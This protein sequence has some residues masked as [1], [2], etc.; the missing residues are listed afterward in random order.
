MDPACKK[1]YNIE[2]VYDVQTVK[3]VKDYYGKVIKTNKDL[4]TGA[5]CTEEPIPANIEA[6][7]KDI[8]PKVL[9]RY[10]GCGSPF[11]PALEGKTVLDLGSGSGRDCFILSKLVG[12][13][14]KVIGVD[15][16]DEQLEIANSY[17]SYHT[18]RFGYD[19]PNVIFKKGYIEDLQSIGIEDESID[20]VVSNG[21]LNLSTNKRNV[22]SEIFRVLKSGGE[23]YFSD[24]FSGSRIPESL[25]KDP[26]L[27]GECLSG[28]LYI[29]DFRRLITSLGYPD[30]RT[31][32]NRKID[33]K[34]SEIKQKIGIIDFYSITIRT[35]KVPLED[36]SEDYGQVAVY[37]GNIE[38]KFVLDNHHVFKIND[39]VPICGNTSAML[40][41][42]RYADYFDIIGESVH[43]GLFKSSG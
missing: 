22:Y 18:D 3:S 6:I 38:D 17:I 32:I 28:A 20:V 16:T 36:R 43:Y 25:V 35:F 2:Q 1:L 33:I 14:G 10:Y 37:K 21:V 23:L 24:V 27:Y 42:T 12:P 9:S 4:K 5:C 30:Y 11:P 34:D 13:N 39:Q 19:K 29:E 7:I 41:K 31:I 15:M 26:I 8:H 40:Q